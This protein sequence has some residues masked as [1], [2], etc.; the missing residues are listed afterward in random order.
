M[1]VEKLSVK[2]PLRPPGQL[3]VVGREPTGMEEQAW[4]SGEQSSDFIHRTRLDS[5][6]TAQ[7]CYSLHGRSGCGVTDF[8]YLILLSTGFWL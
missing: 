7:Q 5:A 8:R 1:R 6:P 4:D 3:D 2:V